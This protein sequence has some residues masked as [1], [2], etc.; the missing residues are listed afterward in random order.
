LTTL[1]P[2]TLRA[3]LLS[4]PDFAAEDETTQR[5]LA[6]MLW[7]S[8]EPRRQHREYPGSATFAKA[9]MRAIWGS[10]K[11]MYAALVGKHFLVMQGSAWEGYTLAFQP[12]E[13]ML[14]A[15]HRCLADPVLSDLLDADGQP[16]SR[17]PAAIDPFR[18]YSGTRAREWAG[19]RPAS[20]VAINEAGLLGG[21]N[22]VMA[23]D[24]RCAPS[25]ITFPIETTRRP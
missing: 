7:M 11:A 1:I 3:H 9:E 14:E 21:S 24:C 15:L 20:I 19:L 12:T 2:A 23:S 13:E 18:A 17:F 10:E 16:V 6:L 5:R 25:G 22:P 8:L 4:C